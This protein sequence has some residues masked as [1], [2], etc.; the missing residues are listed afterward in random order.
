MSET[1]D[2]LDFEQPIAELQKKIEELRYVT[3]GSDINLN[4]EIER[5]QEKSRQLTEQIFSNLSPWQIAQLARHPN[6]PYSLDYI[7]AIFTDWE[8][9]H[10]DRHFADDPAI[11]CGI[12]R[13]EG[14]PVAVVSQ[15]KGRD[16]KERIYRNFGSPRPEGY[17]KALRIMR[18]A[19]KFQLPI[20][21]FID[22]AGAYAGISAEERNQSEAIARNLFEMS[23]LRTPIIATVLGEGGSGGALAI[24]VADHVIMLQY[25]I[26]SVI[27]PEG[28]ASILFKKADRAKEAAAAMRI[29][30]AD[31]LEFRL[32]DEV[33][34]EPLGGS[35]RAPQEMISTLKSCLIKHMDRLS[36]KPL[37]AL[38][39]ERYD[40]LMNYSAYDEASSGVNSAADAHTRQA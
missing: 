21:S 7:S 27:S 36:Q 11:V 10:G 26:Y 5:I 35:H 28:C 25:A 9:L 29:T 8:E 14:R 34:P 6:R 24:G 38:L 13:L 19:E 4:D 32:I 18:L 40:R 16:T 31:L 17:R 1:I 22:T 30:A 3:D 15:Q 33:L 20:I 37:S 2:Y 23:K 39:A 12:A